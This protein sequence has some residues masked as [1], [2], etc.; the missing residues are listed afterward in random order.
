MDY[1]NNFLIVL[2]KGLYPS[3]K[4]RHKKIIGQRIYHIIERIMRRNTTLK[5]QKPTQK[6]QLRLGPKTNLNKI[7]G[8]RHH[9]A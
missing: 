7:I 5:G 2:S 8:T 4:T 1:G 6:I 9:T 3:C